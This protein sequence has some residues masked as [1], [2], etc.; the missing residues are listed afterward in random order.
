MKTYPMP[1]V[2]GPVRLPPEVLAAMNMNFGSGD[3]EPEFL[4]LY[5]QTGANLQKIMQTANP[6]V[7]LCGE[8]M[9]ALWSALKS[10]LTP[11]DR[12]LAVAT[13]L[14]G[15][16]IAQMAESLGA[17]VRK[18]VVPDNQTL[19]DLS[20]IARVIEELQPVMITAVHC[21]TPSG[22]LN[23]LAALGELKQSLRVP[24]LYVDAVSSIGGAPVE[25][26]AWHIDLCLGGAQ[27][28]LSAPPGTA[29]LSVSDAAWRRI[30]EVGYVG[31]DAL[32]PFAEVLQTGFFPYTPNW[33][34]TAALHAGA[35]QILSEGL[36]RCFSRHDRTAEFCRRRLQAMGLTLFAASDAVPSPTV[37][38][39][40]LPEGRSWTDFDAA[41]RRHGLVV[42]GSYGAW[43]GKVFRL[44]HMGTQ[45]D[46]ALAAKAL[47]VIA[48]V[49]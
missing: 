41:L 6:V 20:E 31:Y 37:T 42:G 22:T 47:D 29:F 32:Q 12:V 35:E 15:H 3:L 27:K 5:K 21:E 38:A 13:G 39:V 28:C 7:I 40:H 45:A 24:L 46:E 36:T 1:M 26:D 25:T 34:G 14:F 11:G 10:C 18:I 49:L 2:P 30:A 23:P 48:A 17:V 19:S 9:A 43:R 33:H 44:G 16:G 8:G 4:E